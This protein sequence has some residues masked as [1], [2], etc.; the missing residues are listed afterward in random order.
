MPKP[1]P[2]TAANRQGSLMRTIRHRSFIASVV[3]A[4]VLLLQSV[5]M[6]A[7]HESKRCNLDHQHTVVVTFTKWVT[8]VVPPVPADATPSRFLMAGTTGGDVP[9]DFLGEVIDRKVSTGGTIT[10]QIVALDALYEVLAG[11]HSFTALIQGGQNNA[12]HKALLEGV[13]LDGWRTG[14]RVHVEFTVISSCAGKPAGPCF[15][16]T[17]TIGRDDDN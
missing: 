17:I 4:I 2:V 13:I 1:R 8:S 5:S 16:G 9:G 12:T 3:I 6:L 10:A 7:S 14:E 15:Q 11:D